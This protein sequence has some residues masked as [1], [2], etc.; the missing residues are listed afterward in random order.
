M[1]GHLG[2]PVRPKGTPQNTAKIAAGSPLA[3][4][5]IFLEIIRERFRSDANVGYVWREDLTLTDIIVETSYNAELEARDTVPAVYVTRQQTVPSQIAVGDRVGVRLTDHKEAFIALTTV[6]ISIECVSNDEGESSILG[7]LLQ[8]M[9]LASQDVILREFGFHDMSKPTLGPTVPYQRD[10]NKYSTTID[11]NAQFMARWSQ[12]QVAP[13]LQ[14]IAQRITQRGVDASGYFVDMAINSYRR[15]EIYDPSQAP[16][17]APIPPS[18]V[19]IVGPKGDKGDPGPRGLPGPPGPAGSGGSAGDFAIDQPLTGNVDGTNT[20]F[21][22][23]VPFTNTATAH[24]AVYVNG[25]RQ[26]RGAGNDYV[27]SESIPTAGYNTITF[28]AA[29]L[30]G[31]VI[32]IDFYPASG[33]GGDLAIDQPLVGVLNGINLVFTTSVPFKN[34]ATEREAFYLNGLRLRRG[35]G[36]DYTIS[37]SIPSAGYDT[38]TMEYA[39]QADDT[40]TIDYY[41]V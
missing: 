36:N 19:S 13:L 6:V 38:I 41:P 2:R 9:L 24:E 20:V 34:T 15:G 30:V 28:G 4:Q 3:I 16:P 18:R 40:L 21:T 14:Q 29:P 1:A 39:P 26:K 23:A 27:V 25:L 8:H 5:G 11:F 17:D 10:Q 22:T 37:E 32:T 35:A 33:S 12:V 31:D 7:D